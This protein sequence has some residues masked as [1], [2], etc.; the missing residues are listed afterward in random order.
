[1]CHRLARLPGS[2][3][4]FEYEG[5]GHGFMNGSEGI[6]KLMYKAGLPTDMKQESQDKAWERVFAFFKKTLA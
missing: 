6:K 1:M 4:F 2:S 5:E 3:E